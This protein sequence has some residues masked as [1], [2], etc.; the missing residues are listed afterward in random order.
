MFATFMPT[1]VHAFASSQSSIRIN[2]GTGIHRYQTHSRMSRKF[3]LDFIERR[4]V[5]SVITATTLFNI[6]DSLLKPFSSSLAAASAAEPTFDTT[7]AN[8]RKGPICVIGANGRTG[9]QCVQVG[10]QMGI[11]IRAAT[12][13]GQLS[14]SSSSSLLS[15]VTCDV[16]DSKTIASTIQGCRGVIFAAS[17]SKAGGTAAQID[18]QGLVSVAKACIA[19]KIPHLVIVSSG[20]VSKPF[21]PVYLFLNLFGNIMSE[22]IQGEDAVRDLYRKV[23]NIDNNICTY[24]IIRPGGL[25]EE[26]PLGPKGLELNQGD[27]KSGRISRTDVAA[28]CVQSILLPQYSSKVTFECYNADTAK[29]LQ[30]VG[31]SNL[32]RATS[33]KSD[34]VSGK[35]QRGSN[36]EQLFQ[37]LE[38][39]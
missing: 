3:G 19:N 25:T 16:K 17:A 10:L 8:N 14:S 26:A 24:T 21:S 20:A 18:N 32:F 36:W 1:G 30:T 12:R 7:I 22:K 28:L 13:S 9:Y 15:T 2:D 23:D 37:G 39:E 33:D 34:F 31:L 35:E 27:T 38:Q 4:E 29:P 5:T 6:F 11:P